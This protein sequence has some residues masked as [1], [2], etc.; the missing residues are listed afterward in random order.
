MPAVSN[1]ARFWRLL[2]PAK[3]LRGGGDLIVILGIVKGRELVQILSEP[4]C[5]ARQI[6]KPLSIVAV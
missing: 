3:R 2:D 6:E 1:D 4:R 5:F